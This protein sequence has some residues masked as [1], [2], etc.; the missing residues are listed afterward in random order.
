MTEI[1]KLISKLPKGVGFEW[2]GL[3][4]QGVLSG[5][6]ALALYG[7]SVLVVFL[8]LAALCESWSV[9]FSVMLVIPLGVAGALPRC[10]RP[11]TL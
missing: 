4:Y 9:P 11:R 3:S 10:H 1:A 7:L 5:T 8:C 6:Q 2:T